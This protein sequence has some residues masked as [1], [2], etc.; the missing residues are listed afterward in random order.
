MKVDLLW[1]TRVIGVRDPLYLMWLGKGGQLL[2]TI[3]ADW[4]EIT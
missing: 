4:D 3:A 1:D 2:S